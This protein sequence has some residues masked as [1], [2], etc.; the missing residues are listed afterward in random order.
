GEK[1]LT[2]GAVVS[3][4]LET[5]ALMLE[6]AEFP[7]ASNAVAI[8]VCAPLATLGEYHEQTYGAAVALQTTIPSTLKF[9]WVTPTLSDALAVMEMVLV[10][11]LPLVG[12]VKVTLGGVVS[13]VEFDTVKVT[14]A[15]CVFPAAS[16]AVA[17][18][19][20]DPFPTFP[21]NQAQK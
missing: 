13:A 3:A 1:M 10:G 6:F 20:C 18:A 21:E 8:I 17:E 5:V 12:A 11:V 15:T 19:L 14:L 4:M 16:L 7:P 9:T 2:V